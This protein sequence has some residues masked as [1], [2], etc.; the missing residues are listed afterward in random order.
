MFS[1]TKKVLVGVTGSVAAIKLEE[2]LA[3][4]KLRLVCCEIRVIFTSN[5]LHFIEA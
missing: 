5:S 1:N 3:Q 2:F 4:L